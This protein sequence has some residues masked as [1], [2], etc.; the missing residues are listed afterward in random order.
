MF[1]EFRVVLHYQVKKNAIAQYEKG[2]EEVLSYLADLGARNIDWY[3]S[4]NDS[5]NYIET[6]SLPTAAH[7]HAL[8]KLRR[9]KGHQ[10]FGILENCLEGGLEAARFL[11]VAKPF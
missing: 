6:F 7:C 1:K 9:R 2:M 10:V 4:G 8:K 11:A 3:K 5:C